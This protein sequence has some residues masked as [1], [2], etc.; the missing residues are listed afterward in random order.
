MLGYLSN[1]YWGEFRLR[2]KKRTTILYL[3][4]KKKPSKWESLSL[5]GQPRHLNTAL[6]QG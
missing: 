3:A 1:N 6:T 2:A 4:H 5:V